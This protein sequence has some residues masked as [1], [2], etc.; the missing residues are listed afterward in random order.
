MKRVVL[1]LSFVAA[2]SAPALAQQ[3]VADF[4]KG[5]T[6]RIIVGISVGSGY[7]V[8]AR[9]LQRHFAKHIPGNPTVI[10]QNQ[11]GAGSRTMVNQ[12]VANGPFDGTVI[13]APFNGLPTAPLLQPD[14]VK[15]DPVKIIWIGST[16]RETQVSYLWHTAP[17]KTFADI[18]KTEI[19]T[20]AQAAGT[21]QW[22]YPLVANAV[23][24][25]R[26]KVVSGY[27]STQDIHLAMERG[28]IHGNGSTNWTTLL[29]LN[30]DWVKEK[31]VNVIAQWAMKK[32][33]DLPN[34]PMVLDLAKNDADKAALELLI[35]RLEYGRPYFVPPG[36]PADR[37]Q[38]L[39]RAF[40]ATMKDPEFLADAK[41]FKLEIDPITGEQAQ[42]VIARVLKTPQPVVERVRKAIEVPKAK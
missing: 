41:K 18:M 6:I 22:D 16:N 13:G 5:K 32:H 8:T 9:A 7:D 17:V 33:P 4:Y 21:T 26:F 27:K 28:E 19:V 1:V 31:K 36:V 14:G 39:R 25:T 2:C 11:P 35:A 42:A 12:L 10:V 15:F 40:D 30:G 3:S 24:K 23:L 37:A 38:A 20:G 34:V 29:S